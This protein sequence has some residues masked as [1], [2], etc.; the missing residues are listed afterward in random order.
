MVSDEAGLL[1]DYG[2][3]S[4]SIYDPFYRLGD[5]YWTSPIWMNINF[6]IISALY[7]YSY[8]ESINDVLR[9]DIT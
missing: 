4:L 1:T 9:S 7:R 3:R 2:L 8:D 6:L 5:N